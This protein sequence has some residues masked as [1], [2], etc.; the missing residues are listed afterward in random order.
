LVIGTRAEV[1]ESLKTYGTHD[2]EE[3]IPREFPYWCNG[4]ALIV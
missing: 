3:S 4:E 1:E 2:E